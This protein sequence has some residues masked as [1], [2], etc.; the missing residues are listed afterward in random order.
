MSRTERS[1]ADP[2]HHG[3]L[4]DGSK[5]WIVDLLDNHAR[6]AIGATAVR[7]FTVHCP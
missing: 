4:E 5:A 1:V 6:Y 3:G 7:R 2:W